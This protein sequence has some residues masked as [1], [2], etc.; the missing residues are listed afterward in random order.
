MDSLKVMLLLNMSNITPVR[1]V[2]EAILF[3]EPACKAVMQVTDSCTDVHA[4]ITQHHI[5]LSIRLKY[6]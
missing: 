4:H 2:D 1:S 3:L 6:I 5:F